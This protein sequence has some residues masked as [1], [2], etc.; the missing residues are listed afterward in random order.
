MEIVDYVHKIPFDEISLDSCR[1]FDKFC[2]PHKK[3]KYPQKESAEAAI[4]LVDIVEN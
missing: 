1:F 2:Y 3:K 4:L